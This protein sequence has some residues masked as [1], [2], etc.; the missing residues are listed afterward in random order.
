MRVIVVPWTIVPTTNGVGAKGVDA[1]P[2][3]FRGIE[4]PKRVTDFGMMRDC[5]G[6]EVT[7]SYDNADVMCTFV[8]LANLK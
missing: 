3:V 1:I 2:F 4:T 5:W 7:M 6:G 8:H